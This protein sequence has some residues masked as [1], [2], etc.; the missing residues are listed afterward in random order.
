M[1]YYSS[2]KRMKSCHL[3]YCGWSQ[4]ILCCYHCL[5]AKL[6]LT[7]CNPMGW[8][9]FPWDFPD[10]S[11]GVGCHSFW[12]IFLTQGS[13]LCLLYCRWILYC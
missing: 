6:C 4:R 8:L 3:Q 10:K 9:L 13:K 2:I 5:V 7:V 12:G 1:E 11:T